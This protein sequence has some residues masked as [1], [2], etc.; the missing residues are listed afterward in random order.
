MAVF[1]KKQKMAKRP[2]VL[3]GSTY[4][5]E[6]TFSAMREGVWIHSLSDNLVSV[7]ICKHGA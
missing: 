6:Q 5:C 3:S 2:R 7:C 4:V 1:T